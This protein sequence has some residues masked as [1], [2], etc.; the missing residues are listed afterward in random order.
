MG[1]KWYIFLFFLAVC[2]ENYQAQDYLFLK[3]HNL[4]LIE[5]KGYDSTSVYYSLFKTE[6]PKTFSL[7]RQEVL[8]IRLQS[9]ETVSFYQAQFPDSNLEMLPVMP[10]AIAQQKKNA[11]YFNI[12]NLTILQVG[13]I[14]ERQ[15]KKSPIHLELCFATSLHAT[16]K[17]STEEPL[18]NEENYYFS[19]SKKIYEAGLGLYYHFPI[20]KSGYL[21]LGPIVRAMEFNG[22]LNYTYPVLTK[23]SNPVYVESNGWNGIHASLTCGYNLVG[24]RGIDVNFFLS[25]GKQFRNY[26]HVPV[27]PA[28]KEAL[29]L[30]EHS[31]S[32]W[33]GFCLGH[34]F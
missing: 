8:M 6:N 19:E 18:F 31:L 16:P 3:N 9:D 11:I 25:L 27:N 23:T 5:Y 13:F 12:F 21:Y 17:P 4:I 2:G 7:P 14:Y 1:A 10:S 26:F 28:N 24:K 29:Q 33:L 20:V 32:G 34:K 15:I 22:Q 30:E